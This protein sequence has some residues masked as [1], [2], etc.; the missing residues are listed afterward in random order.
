MLP[1]I[2]NSTARAAAAV[3][4]QTHTIRNVL[5]L[6]SSGPSS[7]SGPSWGNGPGPGGSKFNT[8]SRFYTG[9]NVF[10]VFSVFCFFLMLLTSFLERRSCSD[11]G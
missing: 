10:A 6:Q 5:H 3:Q 7:G 1:H 9:Y 4:N 8:G 2:L 11:A